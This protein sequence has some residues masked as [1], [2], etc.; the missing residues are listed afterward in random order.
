MSNEIEEKKKQLKEAIEALRS[1]EE[2][3]FDLISKK[4]EIEASLGGEFCSLTCGSSPCEAVGNACLST[5][6][7]CKSP[8]AFSRITTEGVKQKA[9]NARVNREKTMQSF[10]SGQST[11]AELDLAIKAEKEAVIDVE[12]AE[13][14]LTAVE[15]ANLNIQAEI[16]RLVTA[17]GI[18]RQAVYEAIYQ[19]L[20]AEIRD[21]VGDRVMQAIAAR[22]R[23]GASDTHMNVLIDLFGDEGPVPSFP[24]FAVC[25]KFAKH[26]EERFGITD[27]TPS[28]DEVG[29]GVG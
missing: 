20:K 16:A 3:A 25:E 15:E 10:V 12:M 29:V 9:I 4:M 8:D 18:R 22:F 13:A 11:R 1:K 23:S 2:Q 7:S 26:L 24:S 14:M 21:T 19:K 28:P 5:R 17:V 6:S 27:E